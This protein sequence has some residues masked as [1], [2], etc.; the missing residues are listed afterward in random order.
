[1]F[2]WAECSSTLYHAHCTYKPMCF[3]APLRLPVIA[4]P[5]LTFRVQDLTTFGLGE[6]ESIRGA[7]A[8]AA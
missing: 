6:E 7:D 2:M 1:M 3:Y 4:Y 5:P 8:C